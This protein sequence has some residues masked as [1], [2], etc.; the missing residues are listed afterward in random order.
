MYAFKPDLCNKDSK[1]LMGIE[2]NLR[3]TYL[4]VRGFGGFISESM[5]TSFILH[6]QV[7]IYVS[8]ESLWVLKG[9]F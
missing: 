8:M 6:F 2:H 1:H 9:L 4:C 3:V 5:G 7:G